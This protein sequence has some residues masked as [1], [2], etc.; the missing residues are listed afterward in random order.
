MAEAIGP[1]N[2][3]GIDPPLRQDE[4]SLEFEG[5]RKTIGKKGRGGRWW[6]FERVVRFV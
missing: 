3:A 2:P 6:N 5:A 1:L 4:E